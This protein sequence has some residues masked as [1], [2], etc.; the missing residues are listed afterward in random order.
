[1]TQRTQTGRDKLRLGLKA[2]VFDIGGVFRDSSEAITEGY[3]RGFAKNRITFS[4]T[5]K[6]VWKLRGIGKYNNSL[7]ACRALLAIHYLDADIDQIIQAANAE[8]EID[9]LISELGEEKL[10]STGAITEAY[11]QFFYS[12]QAKEMIRVIPNSK[13]A[14]DI[15][16]D[17]GYKL[18]IFTNS[19]IASIKRDLG[20]LG[21]ERFGALVSGEDVKHKKPSGEGILKTLEKLGEV[22]EMSAYVGDAPTDIIAAH[23]A[24]CAAIAVLSG[25][26]SKANLE[27]E[28]PELVF[29]DLYEASKFLRKR[30]A[31]K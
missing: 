21:L 2:I 30:Q 10:K 26:G 27:A 5:S 25:M 19:G 28:Y 6:Q 20:W 15:L 9:R 12:D 1:M 13:E 7:E 18:G 22:P 3:R 29:E 14:I 8:A 23:D 17:N 16:S 31:T 24:G 4:F 11:T